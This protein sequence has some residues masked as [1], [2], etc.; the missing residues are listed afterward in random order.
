MKKNWK[1][2]LLFAA[3]LLTSLTALAF[4]LTT[5]T[6]LAITNSTIDSTTIGAT[7]PSTGVF[8][9]VS[10]GITM[11]PECPE[12]GSIAAITGNGADQVLF[13][14]TLNANRLAASKGV[15]I[16]IGLLHSTGTA[17]ANYKLKFG[18]TQIDN[19]NLAN[20]NNTFLDVHQYE[21]FNNSGVQNTQN[22]LRTGILNASSAAGQAVTAS[23]GSASTDFTQSV[24]ITFTFNVAATDA[25]QRL[26]GNVELMQ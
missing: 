10:G 23:A 24:T 22:W 5:V 14:C 25:V 16:R 6:G 17:L 11:P 2:R 20:F 21:I 18:A 26:Y 12:V 4:A 9:S 7:T 8:T 15:R 13:T 3:V 19:F 1:N